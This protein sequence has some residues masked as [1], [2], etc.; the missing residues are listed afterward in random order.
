MVPRLEAQKHPRLLAQPTLAIIHMKIHPYLAGILFLAV[1][2]FFALVLLRDRPHYRMVVRGVD[3]VESQ[4]VKEYWLQERTG[5]SEWETV[6]IY[7][8]WEGEKAMRAMQRKE[9]KRKNQ[10]HTVDVIYPN[11]ANEA[12]GGAE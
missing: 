12:N 5:L 7:P 9:E 4:E 6:E 2:A 3:G 10:A 11:E 8:S 1:A